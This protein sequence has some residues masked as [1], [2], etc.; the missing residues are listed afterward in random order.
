MQLNSR[1]QAHLNCKILQVYLIFSNSQSQKMPLLELL[2]NKNQMQLS[3]EIYLILWKVLNQNTKA[4]RV[5]LIT[6]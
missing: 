1:L 5:K 3:K 6:N 4:I 2:Q